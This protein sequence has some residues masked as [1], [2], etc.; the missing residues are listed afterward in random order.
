VS[1]LHKDCNHFI[2]AA[3]VAIVAIVAIATFIV[4]KFILHRRC[5]C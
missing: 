4:A 5:W 1:S 3:I 2:I